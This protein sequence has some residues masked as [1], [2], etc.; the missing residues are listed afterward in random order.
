MSAAI[1][2]VLAILGDLLI[3]PEPKKTP[4]S[5]T[6]SN[7]QSI[8]SKGSESSNLGVWIDY[9]QG[10]AKFPTLEAFTECCDFLE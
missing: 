9:L 1:Q 5:N 7:S 10:T 2:D 4:V 3:T 6:G 8:C